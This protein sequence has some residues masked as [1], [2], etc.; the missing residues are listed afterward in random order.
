MRNDGVNNLKYL[1][2]ELATLLHE[3]I[4][5]DTVCYINNKLDNQ[6]IDTCLSRD[7]DLEIIKCAHE[8]DA[9]DKI[10]DM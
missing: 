3:F 4:C 7:K 9:T 8:V 6:I 1:D 2:C 5:S 10:V